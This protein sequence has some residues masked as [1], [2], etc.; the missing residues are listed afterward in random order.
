VAVAAGLA[1]FSLG[2]DTAGSGRVP[3][4]CNNLVGFKPTRGLLSTRGVVP[5]CRSLDCISIFALT[6]DDAVTVLDVASGFD[7]DDP[8]SRAPP[9][10]FEPLLLRSAS[11]R[12]IAASFDFSA[13]E[14]PPRGSTRPSSA[15]KRSGASRRTSISNRSSRLPRYALWGLDGGAD[16]APQALLTERPENVAP[17][18]P[19]RHGERPSHNRR[20]NFRAQHRLQALTKSISPIWRA[21]DFLLLPTTGTAYT[22]TQIAADPIA[23]NSDLGFYTNFTNLL[24]LS[25]IAVPAASRRVVFQLGSP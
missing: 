13:T 3:A 12:R 21:I 10:G 20:R 7:P 18:H 5:A 22:L 9:P 15:R 17:G 1:G 11:G 6:V 8:Y 16:L 19:R 2:T 14:R 23:R 4:A 24:D 25:A